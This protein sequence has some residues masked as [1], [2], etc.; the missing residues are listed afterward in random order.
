[1]LNKI[2]YRI[3]LVIIL[4]TCSVKTDSLQWIDSLPK[5]WLLSESEVTEILPEFQK[6]FPIFEERLKAINMESR[7]SLRNI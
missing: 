4:A 3:L 7:H 5:P 6:R 1:M 2:L